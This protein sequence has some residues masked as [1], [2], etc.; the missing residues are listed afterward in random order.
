MRLLNE[1]EMKRRRKP[2]DHRR[3]AARVSPWRC[4]MR[5]GQAS[6]LRP[7]SS[8]GW[9]GRL[10]PKTL[11]WGNRCLGPSAG[12]SVSVS[13]GLGGESFP[14]APNPAPIPHT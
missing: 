2:G 7:A 13:E 6:D 10:P 1:D 14:Q 8:W 12:T 5:T 9:R 3:V 4:Q 11:L